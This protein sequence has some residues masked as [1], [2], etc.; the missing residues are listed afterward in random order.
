MVHINDQTSTD[1]PIA[2]FGGMRLSGNG[3]RVGGQEANIGAFTETQW[4]T[5]NQQ[6]PAYP[7]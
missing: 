7:F 2:P 4:I 1:E 6:P 3:S 5:V